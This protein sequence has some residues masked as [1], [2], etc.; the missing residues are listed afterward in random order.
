MA[1][2]KLDPTSSTI[3][4]TEH[5]APAE[6]ILSESSDRHSWRTEDPEEPQDPLED[7]GMIPSDPPRRNKCPE[8]QV[9]VVSLLTGKEYCADPNDL[10]IDLSSYRVSTIELAEE[11]RINLQ[12]LVDLIRLQGVLEEN[13]RQVDDI[14]RRVTEI[15]PKE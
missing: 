12:A 14:I 3:S 11:G 7:E 8:G 5:A 13:K 10:K 1:K 4:S 9:R 6:D 15:P 2:R